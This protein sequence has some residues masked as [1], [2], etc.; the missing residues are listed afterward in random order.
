MILGWLAAQA[1]DFDLGRLSVTRS[2]ATSGGDVIVC[3]TRPNRHR[4]P[5]PVERD[6][7]ASAEASGMSAL[8][9]ARR[10]GIFAG[11]RRCS[12]REARAYGY[13]GGRDPVRVVARAVRAIV[14]PDR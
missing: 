7:P 9:P 11:E 8:T 13:G 12:K 10:C 3:G 1:A 5:L 6:A 14:D 4:L 2:C